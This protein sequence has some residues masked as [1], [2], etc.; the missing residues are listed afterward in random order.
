MTWKL[1]TDFIPPTIGDFRLEIKNIWT[2]QTIGKAWMAGLCHFEDEPE[3]DDV[4]AE[5]RH[6]CQVLL[7]SGLKAVSP[8]Q[9]AQFNFLDPKFRPVC[10]EVACGKPLEVV[11]LGFE[12]PLFQ[13]KSLEMYMVTKCPD[14]NHGGIQF[15]LELPENWDGEPGFHLMVNFMSPEMFNGECDCGEDHD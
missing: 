13:T 7:A 14:D 10:M 8:V 4:L 2:M 5:S 3:F 1:E 12:Q 11:F 15:T 9:R 6:R